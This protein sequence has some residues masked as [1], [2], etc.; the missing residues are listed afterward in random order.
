MRDGFHFGP[1]FIRMRFVTGSQFSIK[2][3]FSKKMFFLSTVHTYK[4]RLYEFENNAIY[5]VED[6][7]SYDKILKQILFFQHFK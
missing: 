7:F 5:T 1:P 3:S 4:I 2:Y 6:I